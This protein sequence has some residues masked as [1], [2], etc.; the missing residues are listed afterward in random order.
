MTQAHT[1]RT[2]MAGAAAI[3]LSRGQ[4]KRS[5]EPWYRRAR[6]WGQTN[7]TE[8]DPVRYDIGWWREY[9]KKT[10]VQGHYQRRRNRRL[11]SEQV[12]AAPP[13]GIFER[14]RSVRR[15]GQGRA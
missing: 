5:A 10:Q 7:I 11:L 6:R 14:T 13:R 12:S 9:W 4:E 2:F 15:T 1:R 3:G 8:K